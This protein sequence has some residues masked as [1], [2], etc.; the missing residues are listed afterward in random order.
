MR[1]PLIDE[2]MKTCKEKLIEK[3]RKK[4]IRFMCVVCGKGVE[5]NQIISILAENPR[6][7]VEPTWQQLWMC[8]SCCKRIFKRLGRNLV[9]T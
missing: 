7:K 1:I 8:K 6:K 3:I 4:H 5:K 2:K 9:V